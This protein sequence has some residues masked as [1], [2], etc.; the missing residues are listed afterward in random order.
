MF[1]MALIDQGSTGKN[2]NSKELFICNF[3]KSLFVCFLCNCLK[4][5]LFLGLSSIVIPS[6]KANKRLVNISLGTK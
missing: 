3:S 6:D 1:I 4:V 2:E 5:T